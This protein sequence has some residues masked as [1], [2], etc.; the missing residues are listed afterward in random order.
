MKTAACAVAVTLLA[1][2][3][4]LPVPAAAQTALT[5]S[6]HAKRLYLSADAVYDAGL[7]RG[8]ANASHNAYLRGFRDGTSRGAYNSGTYVVSPY[9]ANPV[10][11]AA[12]YS[13]FDRAPG[14]ARPTDT[15]D[16]S[17]GVRSVTYDNGYAADRYDNGYASDRYDA[18]YVPPGLMN[19][20]VSPVAVPPPSE[21]GSAHWSYCSAHYQNFDPASDTFLASDGNR[22]YC[23]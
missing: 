7:R 12:G 10:A 13:L 22:Y 21:V 4:A 17:Y 8:R 20:A 23:R 18:G 11:P 14:Y 16:S 19:A 1:G 5:S 15:Y 2:T 6:S 9:V 3:A